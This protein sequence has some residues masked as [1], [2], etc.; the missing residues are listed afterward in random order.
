MQNDSDT[1]SRVLLALPSVQLDKDLRIIHTN[2]AAAA[3]GVQ[4]GEYL[5][6]PLSGA[7]ENFSLRHEV[8][9]NDGA[10][11]PSDF[12]AECARR[13]RFRIAAFHGFHVVCITYS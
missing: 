2:D 6:C 5:P 7:A 8:C 4:T 10:S 9:L 11:L 12:L 3:C 1:I 13:G